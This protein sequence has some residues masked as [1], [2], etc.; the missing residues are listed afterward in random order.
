MM[1]NEF[2]ERTGFEPTMEEYRE[3][4]EAYYNFDGDKNAFCKHW[5]ETIGEKGMLKARA[6][7]IENLHAWIERKSK[8]MDIALA[9]KDKEIDTLKAK[10][11]REQEWKPWENSKAVKQSEYDHLAS[12]GRGMTDDEA[13]DWIASEF[14][15]STEKIKINRK[16]KTFDVNRHHQLRETG[17]IDRRPYYEATD[18][19][20]VFFTVCGMEYEASNGNLN[21]I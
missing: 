20:Y 6:E 14:G 13:K 9:K 12:S 3:I 1:M 8:D 17:E 15:F 18:W 11:E 10:L 5:M 2:V 21:Q 4:E 19:Y 16:M 7:K